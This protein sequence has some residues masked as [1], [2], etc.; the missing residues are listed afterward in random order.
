V[1]PPTRSGAPPPRER[2]APDNSSRCQATG[3]T[4]NNR[5]GRHGAATWA[6]RHRTRID[7]IY[8]VRDPWTGEHREPTDAELKAVEVAATHLRALG[9][10]GAWQCPESARAAWRCRSCPCQRRDAA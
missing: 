5:P 6:Q 1:S 2:P 3:P 4:Q 8:A 10:Y 7:R 9:L